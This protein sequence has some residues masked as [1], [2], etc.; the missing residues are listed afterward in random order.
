MTLL[1]PSVGHYNTL[2]KTR[3]NFPYHI[4]LKTIPT[5]AHQYSHPLSKPGIAMNTQSALCYRWQF[6]C[7]IRIFFRVY[8]GYC[9]VLRAPLKIASL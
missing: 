9:S 6:H 8:H 7:S 2:Y 3:Y 4:H 1:N 5:G